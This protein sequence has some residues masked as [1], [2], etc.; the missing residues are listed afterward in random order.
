MPYPSAA[1]G[2]LVGLADATITPIAAGLLAATLPVAVREDTVYR[3]VREAARMV[4]G[5]V[6]ALLA[7]AAAHK[8]PI[9]FYPGSGTVVGVMASRRAASTETVAVGAAVAASDARSEAPLRNVAIGPCLQLPIG[10]AVAT[11]MVW[12]FEKSRAAGQPGRRGGC[13]R[14]LAKSG[15]VRLDDGAAL[16]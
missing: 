4:P 11:T 2:D 9:L 10:Y 15:C 3:I 14:D 13:D 8:V 7:P 6:G 16:G 5:T 1:I 12:T